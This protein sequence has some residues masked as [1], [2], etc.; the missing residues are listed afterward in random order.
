[1]TADA[2]KYE[3]IS[4]ENWHAC[5]VIVFGAFASGLDASL[6]T[7]GLDTIGRRLEADLAT[8]QWI[9]TSY[10]LALA[11]S[12]PL[13]GHLSR[14]LGAGRLWMW[15]LAAFTVASLLCAVSPTILALILARVLQG[16]AGGLLIPA[17]QT[18]LGELVGPEQLGRVMATLGIAV[19]VAPALGPF[20]GGLLL[21]HLSWP[22]LFLINLP[23]GGAGLALG[24]R[25]LPAG[26]T[27]P[28][29]LVDWP[30]LALIS[31]ALPTL[32][33]SLTRWGDTGQAT[34]TMIVG[35]LVGAAAL[36]AFV[37]RSRT[38]ASPL[39]SLD[40]YRLPQYRAGSLAATFA[41][42]L[43][44]G[45]G[46]VHTLYLQIGRHL[47]TTQAGLARLAIAGA[48]AVMAPATGRWIDR[49][50]AA[51]VSMTGAVLAV[52]TTAPLVFLPIDTPL[53]MVLPLLV[54][55]GAAV[56]LLA[57]PTTVGAYK[58]LTSRQLPDGVTLVNITQRL[59]GSIGA[60]LC[61]VAIST[62]LPD[63]E[64]A[65]HA[66]FAALLLA[67]GGTL[68]GAITMHRTTHHPIASHD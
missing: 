47:T 56:A 61:A 49:Y 4:R 3:R 8:T 67:A 13:A 15:A 63:S 11:L 28:R 26:A 45:S 10:L 41:G 21:T 27:Q 59:G 46:I 23:L 53:V 40:L 35:A 34:P 60:A 9:V 65:F 48:T 54:L 44:F 42:A 51:P 25:H 29:R 64:N 68:V 38:S 18:L 31:I 7:I 39:L 5:W 2:T 43:V 66:A 17:G 30:G 12:L 24:M 16:L 6:V 58:A 20:V 52:A 57:M 19:S 14:R 55:Y 37:H 22:W 50:G 32:L 36:I 1:M 62:R 33:V